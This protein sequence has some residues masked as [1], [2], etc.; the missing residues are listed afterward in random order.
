MRNS[1]A[2]TLQ[3][4]AAEDE[5]V[6]LLI[7][8]VG[9]GVFEPFAEAFPKR[10]INVGV[11]E[12]NLA[13]VAAGL[14]M[15]GKLPFIYSIANF[16]TFRCLEQ[17]RND[18][19]YHKAN[20]KIVSV[21]G[22]LAYGTLGATHHAT[23]D[24]AIMRAL[25]E[26]VVVAPADPVETELAVRAAHLTVGPVYLR[27]NRAGDPILHTKVPDFAF[28]K[29]NTLR[30]GADVALIACGGIVSNVMDA[31]KALNEQG[32]TARVVSMHTLKPLDT[33]AIAAA[34]REIG[35]V[36]TI[37]EHSLIGGLGSAVAEAMLELGAPRARLRKL[38]LP[39]AFPSLVGS[40]EYLRDQHG[41]SCRGIVA[42]VTD[43]LAEPSD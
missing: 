24:L 9:F 37:E 34:A 12:A 22:G 15:E 16:P 10:Y 41:L 21:G 13:S 32:I 29:A 6:Y 26:M 39:D 14:A 38:A 2:R 28:G 17:V 7:A 8:D 23:Q 19:C 3:Q 43:F 1:F 36:V 18:I 25:P 11:A 35:R 27:L 33:H 20:V 5:R 40:Q 30:E 42:A 31:A 4:L